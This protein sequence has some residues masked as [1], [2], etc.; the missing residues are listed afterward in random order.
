[1]I[2][3]E[4]N[5]LICILGFIC[6]VCQHTNTKTYRAI[7][8]RSS[9]PLAAYF[10]MLVHISLNHQWIK[11]QIGS[12]VHHQ[13]VLER[14]LRQPINQLM[15]WSSTS[16]SKHVIMPTTT[17]TT[18]QQQQQQQSEPTNNSY[19]WGKSHKWYLC[20]KDVLSKESHFEFYLKYFCSICWSFAL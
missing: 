10:P 5:Q 15:L 12:N 9:R 14:V 3:K 6:C 20:K 1:M 17:N 13:R 19:A 18:Q 8:W 11:I 7:C 2:S 4:P 16:L